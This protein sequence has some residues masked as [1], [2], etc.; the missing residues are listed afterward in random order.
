MLPAALPQATRSPAISTTRPRVGC[1]GAPVEAPARR[2]MKFLRL[3]SGLLGLGIALLTPTTFA[4]TDGSARLRVTLNDYNGSGANHWTVA[5]V[6][7]QSGVFIK[8]LWKQGTHYSWTSSQWTTH[9]PQWNAA[10]GGP[11]GSQVVDGYTSATATSYSG[12]NSP[13]ILAWNCRDTNNVLVPDGAY[14]FWVQYAE[15][16]GAGPHTTNGL[17]WVKG[18]V[19]ATNNYANLS[20]HFTAMQVTWTPAAPPTVAPVITSAPPTPTGT[21]GV[22]YNYTCVATGTAPIHFMATGLPPGLTLSLGGLISGIPT[23]PGTFSGTITASNGTP[24]NATQAF[25]L[26]IGTVPVH[27]GSV[28]VLGNDLIL[29]GTGPA[30]GVYAVLTSPDAGPPGLQ[31][32]ALATNSFDPLGDFSFTNALAPGAPRRFYR[33]RVP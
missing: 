28:R 7:T 15:D 2:S 31:W 10:R 16:S 30:N 4:Q 23:Q 13:V 14:K 3:W 32:T 20:P 33:L 17:L 29:R 18:P 5:W 21:V 27:I 26:N 11:N 19:G 8:T 12:T 1:E 25:S 6:T 9:C 22:P 24:P